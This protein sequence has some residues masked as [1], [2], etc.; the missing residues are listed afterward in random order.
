MFTKN[1]PELSPSRTVICI[2]LNESFHTQPDLDK[3]RTKYKIQ[4]IKNEMHQVNIL[5]QKHI[6]PIPTWEA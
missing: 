3:S 6:I 1:P 5:F 2:E 4:L